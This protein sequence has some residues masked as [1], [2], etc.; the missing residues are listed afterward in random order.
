VEAGSA[1]LAVVSLNPAAERMRRH[2]QRRRDGLHCLSVELRETE[3]DA[4]I[5][6]GLLSGD[7]RRNPN[8]IREALYA[9]LDNAL[10]K[11]A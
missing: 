4:L 8:A 6:M 5:R 10:D 3:I 9:F 1:Q 11:A 2:R 7:D